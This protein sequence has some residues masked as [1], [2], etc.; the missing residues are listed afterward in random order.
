[1]IELH[2]DEN[3]NLRTIGGTCKA[4]AVKR[5]GLIKASQEQV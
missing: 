3:G 1:M 2:Y 5:L 4:G